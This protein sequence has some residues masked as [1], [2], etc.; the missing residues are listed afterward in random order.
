MTQANERMQAMEA[1]KKKERAEGDHRSRKGT[2]QGNGG[3]TEEE[4][5]MGAGSTID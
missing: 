2:C 5:R 4:G 1:A 3:R